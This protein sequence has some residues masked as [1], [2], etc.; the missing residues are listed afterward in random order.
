MRARYSAYAL[1]L[2]RY[3][4]KTWHKETRPPLQQLSQHHDMQ[5]ISLKV[6]KTELGRKQ[7]MTGIVAFIA[8]SVQNEKVGQ[9]TESSYFERA[10]GK[11]VY[12]GVESE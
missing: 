5:W 12:V 1:Q 8:T 9:L 3:L 6:T 10:Q 2:P 11:W 7:D 4:F